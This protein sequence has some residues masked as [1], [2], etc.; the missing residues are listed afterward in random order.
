MKITFSQQGKNLVPT[1]GGEVASSPSANHCGLW[2]GSPMA[3]HNPV[4]S[5]AWGVL[6]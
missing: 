4:G 1:V 6:P 3:S 5:L 2:S